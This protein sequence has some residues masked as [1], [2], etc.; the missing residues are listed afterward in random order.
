MNA[1]GQFV[2]NNKEK[3]L[4][5][6]KFLASVVTLKIFSAVSKV[7]NLTITSNISFYLTDAII[8]ERNVVQ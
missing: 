5:F 1:K 3:A 8:I 7:D 4:I 6:N 2:D